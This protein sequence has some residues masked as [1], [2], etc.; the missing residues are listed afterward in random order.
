MKSQIPVLGITDHRLYSFWNF[1]IFVQRQASGVVPCVRFQKSHRMRGGLETKSLQ[2]PNAIPWCFAKSGR[3]TG[4]REPDGLQSVAFDSLSMTTAYPTSSSYRR[5]PWHIMRQLSL[6]Q[7]RVLGFGR[8]SVGLVDSVF[9]FKFQTP[10]QCSHSEV[11][12]LTLLWILQNL[13][14]LMFHFFQLSFF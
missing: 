11:P 7:E 12:S 1:S 14:L 4:K 6:R 8:W 13:S 10:A 5:M 9:S 2:R 3:L